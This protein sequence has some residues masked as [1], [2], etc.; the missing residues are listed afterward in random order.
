MVRFL[1]IKNLALLSLLMGIT[2]AQPPPACGRFIPSSRIVGGSDAEVGSW[3]WQASIQILDSH[4]CGGTLIASRWVLTAAHCF[5]SLSDPSLFAIL[6]GSYNLSNPGPESVL[7]NVKQI[8]MHSNYTSLINGND[9]ALI[10]L[11]SPVNF[12]QRIQPACLPGSSIVFPPRLGC[13]VAG[14]GNIKP[15]VPLPEPE[16]LQE[17]LLPLIDRATCEVLYSDFKEPGMANAIKD[18]MMCAGYMEG[19]K[20]A[21]QA[22]SGGPLLCP[23][24]GDWVLAG[25]V[26]W[27]DVCAAPKR[28]GVYIRVSAH[29]SWILRHAPEVKSNFINALNLT[30]PSNGCSLVAF[31]NIAMLLSL[32][33]NIISIIIY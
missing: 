23:W 5:V 11:E 22:D 14:W 18:D 16:L 3:P 19:G 10:E 24:N 15:Q 2:E 8:I 28:P 20:D 32:I 31:A 6:L 29:T 27:G 21:C 9:I 17:V 4:H 26:S 7:V 13:W 30:T 33:I 1:G 12:T 25:V